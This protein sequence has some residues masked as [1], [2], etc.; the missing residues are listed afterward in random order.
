M[1]NGE[2]DYHYASRLLVVC[3]GKGRKEVRR[4]VEMCT[5]SK[6]ETFYV[7]VQSVL[8]VNVVNQSNKFLIE[9]IWLEIKA[10]LEC[11]SSLTPT[12]SQYA[13]NDGGGE[14]SFLALIDDSCHQQ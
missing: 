4:A 8:K 9:V 6:V 10:K 14:I 13:S 2:A 1:L 3:E 5:K 11:S 12:T 7:D